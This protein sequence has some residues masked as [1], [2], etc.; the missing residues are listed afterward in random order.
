MR[1][2]ARRLCHLRQGT[3]Y[4]RAM[5]D[6]LLSAVTWPA[7][8]NREVHTVCYKARQAGANGARMEQEFVGYLQSRV[9]HAARLALTC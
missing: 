9:G 7:P 3:C 1:H 5:P 4:G 2:K 8:V 6:R